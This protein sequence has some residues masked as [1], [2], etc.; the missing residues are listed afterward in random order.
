MTFNDIFHILNQFSDEEIENLDENTLID[1][2]FNHVTH[3]EVSQD[4]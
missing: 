3:K 1:L 2:D 4:I